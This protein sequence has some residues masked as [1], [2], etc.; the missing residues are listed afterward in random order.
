MSVGSHPALI[1]YPAKAAFGRPVPKSKIYGAGAVSS[2]VKEL[3]V[4]QVEQI[5]WQ[6][7]LAPETINLAAKPDVPE[8]QV[9]SIQLKTD[10]LHQ[11]VLR[12]IDSAVQFPILFELYRGSLGPNQAEQ[13]Q[14]Q[15]QVQVVA[16]YKRPSLSGGDAD[17]SRWVRSDYFS[18]D[19]LPA[20]ST[21]TAM[22][23]A[24][25][26]ANLYA[27]LLQRLIPHSARPQELLADWVARIELAAAKRREVEKLESRLAKEKQFNRKVEINSSLRQLKAELEQ[28]I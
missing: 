22:P 20:S 15:T 14:T 9:F 24:I 18:S 5:V 7:K 4:R 19:W 25:D 6:Y 12:Y 10:E 21:R 8:I 27:A 3:F 2:R 1:S 16:A 26:M 17:A 23:L 11:D 28:L 13:S